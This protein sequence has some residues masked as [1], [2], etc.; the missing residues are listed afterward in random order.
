MA[1][2]QY[3][4]MS[5]IKLLLVKKML[6]KKIRLSHRI[7]R[8]EI[9]ANV[10][11]L[12]VE[13]KLHFKKTKTAVVW[14]G[15]HGVHQ[16]LPKVFRKTGAKSLVKITSVHV[17][18]RSKVTRTRRITIDVWSQLAE[19]NIPSERM[20]TVVVWLDK[21]GVLQDI[22]RVSKRMDV[23]NMVISSLEL[24]VLRSRIKLK[25]KGGKI[26]CYQTRWNR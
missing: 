15:R 21:L 4:G 14:S 22:F 25:R 2:R 5:S 1:R 9:M 13:N 24:A 16:D 7:L 12:H 18:L 26:C 8:L 20:M 6:K 11:H 23:K 17:A 10:L 3:L 19:R